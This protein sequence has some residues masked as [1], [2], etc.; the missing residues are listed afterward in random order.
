MNRKQQVID[1]RKRYPYMTL[2]DI[3]DRT[4]LTGER[5]RQILNRERIP[6]IG[7]YKTLKD[8][9]HPTIKF[10]VPVPRGAPKYKPDTF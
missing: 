6:T 7:V 3:A 2:Q 9:E 4:H 8:S 10:T 5:V 1:L